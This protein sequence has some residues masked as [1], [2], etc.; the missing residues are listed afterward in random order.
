MAS[1]D[2]GLKVAIDGFRQFMRQMGDM[3]KTIDD[4]GRSWSGLSGIAGRAASALGNAARI[5]FR[6]VAGAAVAATT[7]VVA[8]G[9]AMLK[10]AIDAAPLEGIGRTFETFASRGVVSL[11]ALRQASLNTIPD[12]ELM[13]TAN[14]ALAGAAEEIQGPLGEALPRF[15]EIARAAARATG[16]DFNFL[17]SSLVSGVKR[18]SP[19]LI[20]NAQIALSSTEAYERFAEANGLVASE[21]SKEQQQLALVDEILRQGAPMVE[22]F[23]SG[24]LT[25]AERSAQLTTQLKNMKDRIGI[26]LLPAL[27][28][29]LGYLSGL[30]SRIGPRIIKFF[31]NFGSVLNGFISF[32]G[33][34]LEDGDLLND[35]LTHLPNNIRPAAQAIANLLLTG[36]DFIKFIRDAVITGDSLNDWLSHLPEGFRQPAKAIADFILSAITKFIEIRDWI[37]KNWPAITESLKTAWKDVW[38]FIQEIADKF[39]Q[40]FRDNF[41]GIAEDSKGA[42]QSIIDFWNAIVPALDNVWEIIKGIVSGAIDFI[43]GIIQL[44][45]Q[46]AR[47]DWEGAWETIKTTASNLWESI[48]T[49]AAEFIEGVLNI[50]GTNTEEFRETWRNNWEM[51]RVIVAQV[52][53]NVKSAV[54]GAI[55]RV[56]ESIS[57]GSDRISQSWTDTWESIKTT[58]TTA[59]SNIATAI[60]MK[61][62]EIKQSWQSILESIAIIA[63]TIWNSIKESILTSLENLF[64]AMGLDLGE[65]KEQWS[66][67]WQDILLIA[68]TIWERIITFLQEKVIALRTAI[69]DRIDA[70]R[71]WWE[72][73]WTIFTSIIETAWGM[74]ITIIS[75]KIGII[76]AKITEAIQGIR[77]WWTTNWDIFTQVLGTVWNTIVTIVSEKV[78]EIW[79]AITTKVEE[80]RTWWETTWDT[81]SQILGTV[82]DTIITIVSEKAQEIFNTISG[83]ITEIKTWISERVDEFHEVGKNLIDGIKDGI[84]D[85]AG[86]M[87]SA[88]TDTVGNAVQAAKNALGIESPS[89]VFAS[90]GQNMMAGLSQGIGQ[91]EPM[92]RAQI[93]AAV[94]PVSAGSGGG[95]TIDNSRTINAPI[96]APAT[97]NNGMDAAGFSN[98]IERSVVRALQ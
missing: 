48:K 97:I 67:I 88:V 14:E 65:M 53:E 37:V 30:A 87:I 28:T 12:F 6:V 82:W 22:Q 36:I 51:L 73:T 44:N 21:L 26:A 68:S 23:G 95:M 1:E 29:L 20:D 57:D 71:S 18:N 50:I 4:Q 52:F 47:G 86:A 64:T 63:S 24:Q 11:D 31:E 98:M 7:A 58:V 10:L 2:L 91:L 56:R 85:A 25:A 35:W 84:L 72:T 94:M 3:D 89:R 49:I 34:A 27:N 17:F 55:D 59:I 5:G 81:F 93:Q 96:S 75:D 45:L 79:S 78:Q 15:L 54:A 83:R 39:I 9:G 60:S 42:L 80:I 40:F 74:F 33:T 70:L 8:L 66:A 76:Y 19:L 43:L 92:V 13:R 38:T 62:T 46:I 32:I 90:I 77:D 41:P 69:Q 61:I 16:K